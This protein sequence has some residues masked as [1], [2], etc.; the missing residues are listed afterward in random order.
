MQPEVVKMLMKENKLD[1]KKMTRKCQVTVLFSD[2][3]GFTTIS[4]RK[5]AEQVIELLNAYFATQLTQVFKHHG[6]FDKFIGDA[7]MA[8][9]GAP[10]ADEN[11][12]LHAVNCALDMIKAL[13]QFI[14]TLPLEDK[15]FDIGIGLH[16]GEA[17]VGMLGSEQR[18]DYTAIGDTVNVA[19]RIEGQTKGRARLL[20]SSSTRLSLERCINND[21]TAAV[22][23]YKSHGFIELKG[24]DETVELFEVMDM[25][26]KER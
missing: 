7:V 17:V 18:Y 20:I 8:F 10:I 9:W 25:N 26:H 19:S 15:G 4:E 14:E 12:A 6:T 16:S 5:T 2:I 13:N 11:H 22:F 24:R 23:D 3:R 21:Q 1:P